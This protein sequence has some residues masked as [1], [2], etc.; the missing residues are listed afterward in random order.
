VERSGRADVPF[1]VIGVPFRRGAAASSARSVA[2]FFIHTND[3][4]AFLAFSGFPLAEK[5]SKTPKNSGSALTITRA[6]SSEVDAGS[7]K[8]NASKQ[9]A[10]YL[11]LTR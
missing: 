4:P 2:F 6:F 9:K 5:C 3:M 1:K 10:S 8:E 7:R 11:V